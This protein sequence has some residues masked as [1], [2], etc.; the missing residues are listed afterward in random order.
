MIA[1]FSMDADELSC[2]LKLL[3]RFVPRRQA[4]PV[5]S[6]VRVSWR[7]GEAEW[8]AT[9]LDGWLA[10]HA[11]AATHGTEGVACLPYRVLAEIADGVEGNLE[12]RQA[13]Q[14]VEVRAGRARYAV[15]PQP[16][17]QYPEQPARGEQLA[18]LPV[19]VLGRVIRSVA[20]C[21]AED[22]STR[23]VLAGVYWDRATMVATDGTRL[24][25]HR[26]APD[27]GTTLLLDGRSLRAMADMLPPEGVVAVSAGGGKGAGTVH[28]TWAEELRTYHLAA[29][30]VAGRYVD[31]WVVLSSQEPACTARVNRA[32]IERAVRRAAAFG[33]A[34]GQPEAI[35]AVYLTYTQDGLQVRA[36]GDAGSSEDLVECEVAGKTPLTMRADANMILDGLRM[37]QAESVDMLSWGEQAQQEIREAG[38]MDWQYIWLPLVLR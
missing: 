7:D 26:N 17:D 28:F 9:D 22:P 16:A 12:F 11:P 8:T 10:V 35:P 32:A 5:L 4:I 38:S 18:E 2:V 1:V 37:A 14:R 19:D 23:P 29:R 25:V 31:W 21:C 20:P 34:A 33:R 3:G 30:Q 6:C 24:A 15:S 13:G 36:E 27:I